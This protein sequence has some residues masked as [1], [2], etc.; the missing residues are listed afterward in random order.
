MCFIKFCYY[1]VLDTYFFYISTK[2]YYNTTNHFHKIPLLVHVYAWRFLNIIFSLENQL[3]QNNRTGLAVQTLKPVEITPEDAPS[4]WEMFSDKH[5]AHLSESFL[6]H[7]VKL[8]NVFHHVLDELAPALPQN[9]PVLGGLPTASSLSPIKRKKSDLDK[10][11][12]ISPGKLTEKDE[13]TER[14]KE[15]AKA[16]AMGYFCNLP[17]YMKIY[18]TLR[19]AYT[20]YK[21]SVVFVYNM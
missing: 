12:I 5:F 3:Q 15:I 11:K 16:N 17:H 6:N 10:S 8:L 14:M 2:F 9:K 20:N 7:V 1:R 18:E 4:L 21:V 19:T 13:K